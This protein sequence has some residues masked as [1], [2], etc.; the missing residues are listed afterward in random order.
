VI[1][2]VGN[3][4][5]SFGAWSLEASRLPG[6][7]APGRVLSEVASAG[8]LGRGDVGLRAFLGDWKLVRAFGGEWELYSMELDRTELRDVSA[9]QPA[10][11]RELAALCGPSGRR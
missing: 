8:Y 7:P 2:R 4:P 3:A 9:E 10:L 6:V 11:V 1:R 5:V